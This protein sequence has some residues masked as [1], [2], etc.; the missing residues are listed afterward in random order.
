VPDAPPP[1]SSA[2]VPLQVDKRALA[3]WEA[4]QQTERAAIAG[5]VA[6]LPGV[7]VGVP[8]PAAH[9][10][11]APS[12]PI[13]ALAAPVKPAAAAPQS[14]S[15]A[16]SEEAPAPQ[17]EEDA[18]GESAQGGAAPEAPP[19]GGGRAGDEDEEGAWVKPDRLWTGASQPGSPQSSG[20]AAHEQARLAAPCVCARGSQPGRSSCWRMHEALPH[21]RRCT[22]RL[23]G[24]DAGPAPGCCVNVAGTVRSG[25]HTNQGLPQR[26]GPAPVC[27]LCCS[28]ALPFHAKSSPQA[29][30]EEL[31]T[32]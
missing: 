15:A 3:A 19:A 24:S 11:P 32:A 10:A 2:I 14:A 8:P 1:A 7:G 5:E 16:G 31:C 26:P 6:G 30:M 17:D 18:A 12:P 23:Q 13:A 9:D 20:A 4:A 28:C 25:S 22:C 29:T 27:M 21:A